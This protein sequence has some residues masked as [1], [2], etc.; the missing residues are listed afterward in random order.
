MDLE[1]PGRLLLSSISV[2][3]TPMSQLYNLVCFWN[4]RMSRPQARYSR[5]VVLLL[6]ARR[7]LVLS[8]IVKLGLSVL[9]P[10]T[11]DE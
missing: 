7:N 8:T 3:K 5:G 6:F 11:M 4:F 10:S 9:R 1:T 2:R